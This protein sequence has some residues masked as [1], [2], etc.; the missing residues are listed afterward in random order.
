[1]NIFLTLFFKIL[2]RFPQEVNM[3]HISAL[4]MWERLSEDIQIA[5]E[6]HARTD[7]RYC[8]SSDYMNLFFKLKWFYNKHVAMI[9][10]QK[11]IIPEYPRLV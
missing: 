10:S 7:T 1:M 4:C 3:G 8:K 9:P 6:V 11:D 5:L 2:F